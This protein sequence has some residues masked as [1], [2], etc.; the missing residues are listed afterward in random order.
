MKNRS[1]Y[2]LL[3]LFAVLDF[4]PAGLR[5]QMYL[6]GRHLYSQNGEKV[7]LRGVNEMFVWS[8]DKSGWSTFPQIEQTGANSV[9]I[10]WNTSGSAQDLKNCLYNCVTR[11]RAIAIV[12]L[13]DATG[14]INK[15]QTC[16]DYWKRSDVKQAIQDFRKWTLLNIANEAGD[17]NVSDQTFKDKY[18]NAISQLRGAG[19]TVPLVV[20]ATGY[21]QNFEQIKRTWS[22]IFNSDPQRKTLFSVHTYWTTGGNTLINNLANDVKNLN[23]PFFIGEGP[24][25]VGWDCNTPIDYNYAMQR[26]QENEIGWLAWSWG[27]VQNGNCNTNRSYDMTYNGV[28]GNW[29]SQWARDVAYANQFS[30]K[31]TSRRPNSIYNSNP[32]GRLEEEEIVAPADGVATAF[33]TPARGR[34]YGRAEAGGPVQ[35]TLT[36]LLGRVARAQTAPEGNGQPVTLELPGVPPGLYLLKV[37]Q[38]GHTSTT[39]VQVE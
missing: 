19:Y 7:I 30:L 4:A 9:R 34:V 18:K 35:I 13:S 21:G 20:D 8:N 29:V 16:L 36:D 26:F 23:I 39:R 11:G 1:T 3:L 38:N 5:A 14:D 27:L 28:Y 25:K 24:Q 12:T 15:L 17:G 32:F 6:S 2:F 22:E 31:N 37:R 33:P 10:F